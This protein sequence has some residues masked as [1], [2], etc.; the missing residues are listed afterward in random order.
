MMYGKMFHSN[1]QTLQNTFDGI[2]VVLREYVHIVSLLS[3]LHIHY[4]LCPG[5]LM[6]HMKDQTL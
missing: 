6:H 4:I 2:S 5:R 3:N 1:G